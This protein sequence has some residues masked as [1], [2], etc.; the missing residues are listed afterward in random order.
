VNFTAPHDP[1]LLPSGY[2]GKYRPDQIPLPGNF[3]PEHPFDHGN[4]MGRD[5]RL[6]PWPRTGEQVRDVTAMYYAVIS[7]LDAQIGRILD[8]LSETGQAEQTLVIFTSDHGVALGSH[9][10]RGK[11]NMYEHTVGVP[12]ILSG[13][14]V[15]EGRRC[16]AQVYLRDIFPTVCE[17]AG[18]P[19]PTTVTAES[20]AAVVTGE[21]DGIRSFVF[22]YFRDKQRMIR[23]DRW[24][25]IQY[26]HLDR[27]QLFDLQN[28]PLERN[29]LS[30]D[31][32]YAR[33]RRALAAKLRSSQQAAGDSLISADAN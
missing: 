29:D 21:A 32:Q 1:L 5:E 13:P 4:L 18:V 7:H 27:W 19:I 23:T 10:L 30:Q 2:A 28:D 12:L 8:A 16:D 31:P 3:L 20:F 17:L 26:P 15:P 24:K 22:C 14:G 25:L 9:G 11:Q 33:T 6:L